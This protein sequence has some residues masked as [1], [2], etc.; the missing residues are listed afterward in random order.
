[1]ALRFAGFHSILCDGLIQLVCV[2]QEWKEEEAEKRKKKKKKADESKPSKKKTSATGRIGAIHTIYLIER[3]S[4]HVWVLQA[5]SAQVPARTDLPRN[6][7][8]QYV[9][10]PMSFVVT[11]VSDFSVR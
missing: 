3:G 11:V 5:R 1:M 7:R 10:F 6:A 8:K 2:L 4:E 9:T